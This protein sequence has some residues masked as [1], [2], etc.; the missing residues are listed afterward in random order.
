MYIIFTFRKIFNRM[1]VFSKLLH[2]FL[3]HRY[4]KWAK[5]Q[6][7]ADFYHY[8]PSASIFN[9]TFFKD[10]L[11]IIWTTPNWFY[12]KNGPY[13]SHCATKL[14]WKCTKNNQFIENYHKKLSQWAIFSKNWQNF[15]SSKY[16]ILKFI[17][18]CN[19][20]K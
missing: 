14:I 19:E 17:W 9:Q 18:I 1:T 7:L 3:T 5:K 16:R 4:W 12:P 6:F 8:G 20:Q 10:F 15:S 13:S 11:E 2:L